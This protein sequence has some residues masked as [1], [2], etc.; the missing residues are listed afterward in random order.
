MCG[1]R[2]CTGETNYARGRKIWPA[3]GGSV[4]R[5]AWDSGEGGLAAGMPRSA[6]RMGPSSDRRATSR[7]RPGCSAHGR[8]ASISAVARRHG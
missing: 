6:G 8:R 3:A 7:P 1:A 4:L 2:A 5:E